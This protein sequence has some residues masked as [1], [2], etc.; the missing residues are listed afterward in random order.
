MKSVYF[1]AFATLT[2]GQFLLATPSAT[3]P[4]PIELQPENS[5]LRLTFS[6]S[7]VT[8]LFQP[9]RKE[10]DA[11]KSAVWVPGTALC[12]VEKSAISVGDEAV[13][14]FIKGLKRF[15]SSRSYLGKGMK[16][17]LPKAQIFFMGSA[18]ENQEKVSIDP[19]LPENAKKKFLVELRGASVPAELMLPLSSQPSSNN[20]IQLV[21]TRAPS[22]TAIEY[23]LSEKILTDP[24]STV[25]ILFIGKQSEKLLRVAALDVTS[26]EGEDGLWGSVSV[27]QVDG[28][29]TVVAV[30]VVSNKKGD[31]WVQ[32]DEVQVTRTATGVL[33]GFGSALGFWGLVSFFS[34][35]AKPNLKWYFTAFRFAVTPMGRFSVSLAQAFFWTA[36]V[37]GAG[38]Y[39][40]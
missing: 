21:Q 20:P 12:P 36:I 29:N 32:V 37:L 25:T 13:P 30:C 4:I 33:L 3:Y 9:K 27:P 16:Y 7:E 14:V 2:F 26:R 34:R 19:A 17:S 1:L 11:E 31:H 40:Y 5:V 6:G 8:R 23:Q 39:V 10:K 28:D 35:H 24:T 22:E 18:E 38:V 15:E